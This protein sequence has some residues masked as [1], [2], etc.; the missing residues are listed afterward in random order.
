MSETLTHRTV[1]N[2][3]YSLIGFVWPL[4]LSFVATPIIIR[5]LGSSRFGF[6]A[7]LNSTL[8]LFGLLDFGISYTFTKK[9]SENRE[10]QSSSDLSAIFSSSTILYFILGFV[11]M[12]AFLF[13][14]SV[15]KV[16]FKI[17]DG[18]ISSYSLAFFI[19]GVVF[20]MKMLTVTISLIPYSLQKQGIPTKVSLFNNALLQL[21]SIAVIKTGHGIMGLLVLQLI[22]AAFLLLSYYFIWHRIAPSLK[23]IFVFPK[24]VLKTISQQGFWVFLSNTMGNILAQADKFVLGAIWGPV[25]VGYYSAAQMLPEKIS[26]TAFALSHGF[27]PIFSEASQGQSSTEKVKTIFRRSLRIITIITGGLTVLVL[28]FGYS[29]VKFWISKEFADQG[30]LAI[31]FLGVTYFLLSFNSFFNSFL[32]GLHALKF[33]ALSALITAVVDLIFMV[34]LIPKFGLNGAAFAYMLSGIPILIILYYIEK[35]YLSSKQR[36]IFTYYFKVFGQVLFTAIITYFAATLLFVPFVSGLT[37]VMVFGAATF[38]GYILLIWLF[39]FYSE[40][41]YQIVKNYLSKFVYYF[42]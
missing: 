7:L 33:L 41:D 9:L 34:I 15:F 12:L 19:L 2:T 17:P 36:D 1:K 10:D 37:Y 27:F 3:I 4:V 21:G 31:L 18:Y 32:S 40:E 13:L 20:L 24:S 29:F 6:F 23:F 16:L 22:S 11:V 25:A 26:A 35:R 28:V 14:P 8:T 42:K 39:G 5:G 38:I 30:M